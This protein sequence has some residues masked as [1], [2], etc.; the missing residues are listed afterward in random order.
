LFE[1][2]EE[3]KNLCLSCLILVRNK[4][5]NYFQRIT[6]QPNRHLRQTQT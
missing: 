2:V 3:V 6:N 1:F 5:T 4:E